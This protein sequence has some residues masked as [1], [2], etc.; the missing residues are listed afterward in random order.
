MDSLM[1][2]VIYENRF[3]SKKKVFCALPLSHNCYDLS[4]FKY[5]YNSMIQWF[6]SWKKGTLFCWMHLLSIS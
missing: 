1:R 3:L 4:I 6:E 2:I 5:I